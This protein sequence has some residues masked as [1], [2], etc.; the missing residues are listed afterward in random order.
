MTKV[1]VNFQVIFWYTSKGVDVFRAFW[2]PLPPTLCKT[3]LFIHKFMGLNC[4]LLYVSIVVIRYV[5]VCIHKA[6]RPM[7]D[8]F[9]ALSFYMIINLVSFLA[10]FGLFYIERTVPILEV[11]FWNDLLINL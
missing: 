7:D 10:T 9:I 3:K 5:I 1:N 2:G 8:N 11:T 4:V 6:L